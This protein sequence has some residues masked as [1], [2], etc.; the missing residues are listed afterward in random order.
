MASPSSR[1][2]L[3]TGASSGIGA[4][5]VHQLLAGGWRV[6]AAARRVEAMEALAAAGAAVMPL[7]VADAASRQALVEQVL[8][9]EGPIE[10]LVNNAGY[11]HIGPMETVDLA[12]ARAMFEVNLFGLMGL[13]QLVLP[14]MRE[15][16]RGRVVNVSSMAG[17]VVTPGAGW[18]GASKFALEGLSDALRLELQPFGIQVV[19]IQPGL[20]RTAFAEVTAPSMEANLGSAVYGPMMRRVAA[21]WERVYRRASEPELVARTIGRALEEPTPEAR[22]ACGHQAAV[23]MVAHRLMPTRLW[24][25]L[26]RREMT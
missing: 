24:D 6:V 12:D 16:G 17:E 19:V 22:Y 14:S 4:A 2:A 9:R 5:T 26:L 18:Y 3:V 25:A 8:A 1:L 20:I 21:A 11:G 23:S 15:R 7:D 10:A 13:T